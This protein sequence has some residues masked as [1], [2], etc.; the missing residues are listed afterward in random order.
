VYCELCTPT[1]FHP[2]SIVNSLCNDHSMC[3]LYSAPAVRALNAKQTINKYISIIYYASAST[4][5]PITNASKLRIDHSPLCDHTT[6]HCACT[7]RFNFTFT[8]CIDLLH[9]NV[10]TASLFSVSFVLNEYVV[11]NGRTAVVLVFVFSCLLH[12]TIY[13]RIVAPDTAHTGRMHGPILHSEGAD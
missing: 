11:A 2:R 12:S 3:T 8:L 13:I 5:H 9:C 1:T 6:M 4:V 7:H 10:C